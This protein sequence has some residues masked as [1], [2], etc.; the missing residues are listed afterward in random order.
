MIGVAGWLVALALALCLLRAR[1]VLTRRAELVARACHELRRPLTAARL[2]VELVARD[3]P[4]RG[5]T[6][7]AID[8]E[9][10]CAG[11]AVED[12]S[13]ALLGSSGPLRVGLVDVR[14]LVA[15]AV[16]AFRPL[17]RASGVELDLRWRGEPT[18]VPG[19]RLRLA[20]ATSN[21]IANA[22]E[23]GGGRVQLQGHVGDGRLEIAVTDEGPGLGAP[24]AELARNR[25][26]GD[27]RRGHGLAIAAEV[28][29]RHGGELIAPASGVG[30]LAL[31]LPLPLR[32]D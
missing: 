20:Q 21:L 18:A 10:A 3:G 29:H 5:R 9:L 8:L 2:G 6:L 13:V 27:P 24:V 11:V 25:R 28:A 32:H 1:S 23:H 30:E 22:I 26:R 31:S 17:A 12:L 7:D 19:D 4:E 14:A 15:D 16:E